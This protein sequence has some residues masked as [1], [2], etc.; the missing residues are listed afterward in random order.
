MAYKIQFTE[1]QN[2]IFLTQNFNGNKGKKIRSVLSYLIKYSENNVITKS[3]N[4]LYSMYK[5]YHKE[6]SRTY[7]YK[8]IKLLN[9][10]ELIEIKDKVYKIVNK[11]VYK[12]KPPETI[13]N[14]SVGHGSK[15]PN[16][17]LYKD[18]NTIYTLNKSILDALKSQCIDRYSKISS[19][20]T[21]GN[22][23]LDSVGC[24]KFYT[25]QMVIRK[26]R[27]YYKG[28]DLQGAVAYIKSI[29][30]EMTDRYGLI[31]QQADI[32]PVSNYN[33][34]LA[35]NNFKPRNYNYIALE[36]ALVYG[37]NYELP[38]Y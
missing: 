34:P 18:N 29:V 9:D 6:V 28:I 4:K 5:R 20:M 25:R 11:K 24:S 31:E 23:I 10:M 8:L 13:E 33:N 1:H 22:A 32:V 17:E 38:R 27:K 30:K 16:Y 12:E 14:T 21:I 36:N 3:L 19:F 15:K 7:F 2:N 35:F 37:D 26:I